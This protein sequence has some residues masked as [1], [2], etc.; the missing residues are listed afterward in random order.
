MSF[1]SAIWKNPELRLDEDKDIERKASWLELFYDLVFIAVIAELAHKLQSDLSIG[2]FIVYMGLFLPAWWIWVGSTFYNDRFEQDDISHRIFTFLG[3]IPICFMAVSIH[4]ALKESANNYA[5]SYAAARIILTIMWLRA[6]KSNKYTRIMTQR[7]AIGFTL[8]ALLWISSIFV[9][10]PSRF[11]IWTFAMVIDILTPYTTMNLHKNMPAISRSHLPERFGLF[12][13]LAIAESVLGAI[14]GISQIH[15]FSFIDATIAILCLIIAFQ[16][17][18][19]YFDHVLQNPFKSKIHNVLNW[20]Y[21]HF[22]LVAMITALGV[23]M[24]AH[25]KHYHDYS[26]LKENLLIAGSLSLILVIMALIEHLSDRKEENRTFSLL[27]MKFI[28][29]ILIFTLGW[30]SIQLGRVV[31]FLSIVIIMIIQII[32]GQYVFN[33][34]TNK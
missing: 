34:I 3:M 24:K 4:G 32:H 19:I 17:W 31:F 7:F 11:F 6:G 26:V 13:I 20:S 8:S 27:I 1:L 5:L 18:W 2:N 12:I 25:I 21:L 30:F 28:S 29:A 33:R 10:S 9:S 23:G 22:P 15:H 14:Y 16:V